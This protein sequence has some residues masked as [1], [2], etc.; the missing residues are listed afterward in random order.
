MASRL[1]ALQ[2]LQGACQL[3]L[4]RRVAM[5][6]SVCL[7]QGPTGEALSWIVAAAPTLAVWT[8][9]RSYQRSGKMVA[10]S[11]EAGRWLADH[12]WQLADLD[13]RLANPVALDGA[14][15]PAEVAW[16]GDPLMQIGLV[17]SRLAGASQQPDG[18]S[19]Q[20][21]WLALVNGTRR[22]LA[23]ASTRGAP[24]VGSHPAD[25]LLPD[26]FLLLLDKLH[27]D[28]A[29]RDPVILLA[30]DMLRRAERALT[31]EQ[32]DD[33]QAKRAMAD[34]A[35]WLPDEEMNEAPALPLDLVQLV[36]RIARMETMEE[37]FDRQLEEEKLHALKELAQGAG[38]EINNPLANIAILAQSLLRN[39]SDPERQWMLASINSQAFR[40]TEMIADMM[41][42]A[43]P[44]RLEL[45]P[46][47]VVTLVHRAVDEISDR[48]DQ[49]GVAIRVEEGV[50]PLLVEADEN[51]L[52][53]AI[54]AVCVNSL[55]ACSHGGLVEVMIREQ[56][57]D[58]RGH[59]RAAVIEIRDD[60]PGIPAEV[61]PHIFS[62][63]YSGRE[64]G[65]GL[66]F[67]LSKSWRIVTEHGGRIDV[68][69][70]LAGARLM[71]SLPL[72]EK[73]AA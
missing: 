66:G 68:D 10:T 30:R 71:I 1:P 22:W 42:F 33:P 53:E 35:D 64:A 48:A 39:E 51:H 34:L 50:G 16:Q 27:D 38:H 69:Q 44:P 65:R 36:R 13:D 2:F 7:L 49:A 21:A 28:Q 41:L 47:N 43:K 37:N 4:P 73:P 32:A 8:I 62:P 29:T 17:A 58:G 70:P 14:S 24:G 25:R 5:R 72:V 3:V 26:S 60:G 23:T 9:C 31:D 54:K 63:F 45:Q 6:L 46:L 40:A 15:M 12:W 61:R 67:G 11:E 57:G 52:V 20:A 56:P 55:E 18:I 19:R 59:G